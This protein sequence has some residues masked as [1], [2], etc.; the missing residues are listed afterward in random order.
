MS[1]TALA[2]SLAPYLPGFLLRRIAAR[3]APPMAPSEERQQG[4]V[5]FVD[6]A[7][8]TQLT[9][10]LA[11]RGPAGAELL[12]EALNSYFGRMTD[13][14]SE[15]GGEVA[16]F[17]G[18]AALALWPT[19]RPEEL[20]RLTVL[21]AQCART[22]C[23]ELY[24]FS[25]VPDV[26]LMQRAAVAVGSA[27]VLEVGGVEG[28]WLPFVA[29]TSI[30][31]LELAGRL[32][33]PGQVVLSPEAW[34]LVRERCEGVPLEGG[35][36]RVEALRGL[37][38][39]PGPPPTP[40][41]SEVLVRP[42]LPEGL[43]QRLTAGHG[44]WLAEFRRVS[45][46]FIHLPDVDYAAPDTL[47]RMQAVSTAVQRTL[48]RYQGHVYQ[49]VMDDKGTGLIAA[50]G[51]PPLGQ[52][53][54]AERAVE[55][56]EAIHQELTALAL[57][58]SIGIAT[59]RMFCGPYGSATRRQ[60]TVLGS[61]MNLAARLMQAS[62]GGILC[63]SATV[64]R[65]RAR[66]S[67]E[68][69]PA[70]TVK[71]RAEPVAVFRPLASERRQR[72]AGRGAL[73]G[74]EA[75]RQRLA[76][77]VRE[78]QEGH[79]AV[80]VV[81]GEAGIGKSTLLEELARQ[82]QG[83]G[84]RVLRGAADPV[85]KSTPYYA[86]RELL[87]QLLGAAPEESGAALG[88]RVPSLLEGDARLLEW[89]PL[90]NLILPLGLPENDITR[91]MTGEARAEGL[92]E[93]LLHLLER[94]TKA[95]PTLLVLDDV[96]WMDSTSAALAMVVARRASR[97]LLVVA[98]R[99]Q[100]ETELAAGQALIDWPG[101]V[102]LLLEKLSAEE[103]S[104]LVCRRLGV[105]ELPGEVLR[106]IMERAEGHPFY[107]EELALA[108]KEAG[109]IEVHGAACRVAAGAGDLSRISFPD[110]VQGVITSRID[111]LVPHEQLALK[112]ASVI[113][114]VFSWDILSSV[115]PIGADL[116]RLP[117]G[118]QNLERVD[119]TRLERPEPDPAY[120]FKHAITQEVAYNTLLF[121]QRR[122][123]HREIALRY[124]QRGA[125]V[126][127]EFYP[128]LAHHWDRAGE[129]PKAIG[130]MEK[131]GEAA[132]RGFS[133]REAESFLQRAAELAE[134]HPPANEPVRR[135]IRELNLGLARHQQADYARA[136]EHYFRSLEL[137]R[138]RAPRSRSAIVLSMLRHLGRQIAH[139]HWPSRFLDRVRGERREDMLHACRIYGELTNVAWYRG[140][141]LALMHCTFTRLN[142]GEQAGSAP[143]IMVGSS[144]LA[145]ALGL[146]GW[147]GMAR[148]YLGRALALA[149][150]ARHPAMDGMVYV[151]AAVYAIGAGFWEEA[152]AH[153]QRAC[154][155]LA[156]L[157]DRNVWEGCRAL[158]GYVHLSR[159]EFDAALRC[160]D[161]AYASARSGTAQARIWARNGHLATLLPQGE[162]PQ[163]MVEEL[164]A[165]VEEYSGTAE[166][167][168]GHG[169]LAQAYL[170]RDALEEARASAATAL[171]LLKEKQPMSSY[172]PFW[173]LA[174]MTRVYLELCERGV[175]GQ[176]AAGLRRQAGE[177]C[178]LL[179]SFSRMFPL[180]RAQAALCDA[181]FAALEGRH[182]R[183]RRRLRQGV[184][185]AR[186]LQMPYD[187]ALLHLELA[188]RLEPSDP[189]RAE[190]LSEAERLFSR[191]G[192]KHGLTLTR[193]LG[194][195][196]ERALASSF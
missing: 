3:S 94:V 84:V 192:A 173:G 41:P 35:C 24:G 73:V 133:S 14:I 72:Q 7:G 61:A 150:Q 193:G 165:L 40:V 69:L 141:A 11:Q 184:A 74:R 82:A 58:P 66:H 178:K 57:P 60:Y 183:A 191:S 1:D 190:S 89:S 93:L 67:F 166:S 134:Q 130:Y 103:I 53:N 33:N 45:A 87:R 179:R 186:Q 56:A 112:T 102:R 131:A 108:L 111:R 188:R 138:W 151:Q 4:V 189:L 80:L 143:E 156:R 18:D 48:S 34:A 95:A 19:Q 127:A 109:L 149:Q 16:L 96:H 142:L 147:H 90:L 25:P 39:L 148:S 126:P 32:G 132:L 79:G 5:L 6:V 187:E 157:G 161:D 196:G 117:E 110:S 62:G 68:A 88:A 81:Q 160:F 107:S 12:S 9:E 172:V 75:H 168:A 65:A 154:E 51:L 174:A 194:A 144:G 17:A 106:F 145:V 30:A 105:A 122:Q 170:R 146:L 121:A 118:L 140:D 195:T 63:D 98:S 26:T 52:E 180:A 128:L 176:D 77:L 158:N 49:L 153:S 167:M 54:D 101:A 169:L 171:R 59:G 28:R 42:Y 129:V 139:R 21:A 162:V 43:L 113:G 185:I 22:V 37:E 44:Q 120:R 119:L 13:L 159:G 99:P 29:G 104:A 71:G 164:Q 181:W 123:L 85:E 177:A 125:E 92:Q 116:P 23:R 70:I 64:E 155:L 20:G 47:E 2:N 38:P 76:E 182:P 78:L 97:L 10:R 46:L 15:H 100:G 152:I 83:Q 27:A 50:F 175:G 91:S 114:R 31:R 55:A 115:Y 86:W 124:E 8:F 36:V 137:R 136:C 135:S 163:A